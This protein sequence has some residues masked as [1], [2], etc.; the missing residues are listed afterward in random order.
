MRNMFFAAVCAL[1][2]ICALCPPSASAFDMNDIN[3]AIDVMDRLK[4]IGG[5]GSGGGGSAA[6]APSSGGTVQTQSYQSGGRTFTF[7]SLPQ[8]VQE[9]NALIAN[10]EKSPYA[11]AALVVAAY[12]RYET[13]TKD[14]IAM[15]NV[16]KGPETLSREDERFLRD[17]IGDAG[18]VPR[19]FFDG[20]VPDNDYTPT[21]PYTITVTDNSYSFVEDGYAR[22]FIKSN[23]ADSARPIT[24]RTKPSTGEWFFWGSQGFLM[25]IRKPASTDKWK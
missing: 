4:R 22:L 9:L 16:L 19:S 12:C 6:P 21:V 15:I 20:A 14:C 7:D 11:T 8:N 24:L 2:V 10:M 1:A 3:K 5:S 18:Y 25:S 17:R 23:G 13:S